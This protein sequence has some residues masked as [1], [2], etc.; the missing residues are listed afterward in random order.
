MSRAI[1]PSGRCLRLTAAYR[2]PPAWRCVTLPPRKAEQPSPLRGSG[3]GLIASRRLGCRRGSLT[4]AEHCRAHRRVL[5]QPPPIEQLA[6]RY[7]RERQGRDE[8]GTPIRRGV[9]VQRMRVRLV[10][11]HEH[12][13][14]SGQVRAQLRPSRQVPGGRFG[15][16]LARGARAALDLDQDADAQRWLAGPRRRCRPAARRRSGQRCQRRSV[17]ARRPSRAESRCCIAA[18]PGSRRRAPWRPPIRLLARR[19]GPGTRRPAMLVARE[20]RAQWRLHRWL[21]GQRGSHPARR[22]RHEL[23]NRRAAL[24]TST[25]SSTTA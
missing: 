22:R 18:D 8:L 12:D 24:A 6:G 4:A 17:P 1:R 11:Q 3:V 23:R 16:A 14:V 9:P 7:H 25:P 21:S 19:A 13:A 15:Q 5:A 2:G 20:R 10:V